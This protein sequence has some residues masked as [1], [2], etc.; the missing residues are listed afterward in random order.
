M[1]FIGIVGFSGRGKSSLA[2]SL[3]AT[4]V[5]S[6]LRVGFLKHTHH[7]KPVTSAGDTSRLLAAGASEAWLAGNGWAIRYTEGSSE[8]HEPMTLEKLRRVVQGEVVIIEGFKTAASWPCLAVVRDMTELEKI[9]ANVS[10]VITE[11]PIELA[12]PRFRPSD[13]EAIAEFA[14]TIAR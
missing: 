1:A 6:G 8:L 11:V 14:L 2:E 10:A 13:V 12:L 7:E 3:T 9:Q 5:R 4:Y